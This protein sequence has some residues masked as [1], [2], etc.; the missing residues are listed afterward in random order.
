MFPDMPLKTRIPCAWRKSSPRSVG[1]LGH[2]SI[3]IVTSDHRPP[4][5][6]HHC[7]GEGSQIYQRYDSTSRGIRFLT[8]RVDRLKSSRFG[9]TDII[10]HI[11]QCFDESTKRLFN[12]SD[13][14]SY[15]QF[16]SP[17]EKAPSLGIQ[18]GKMKLS[19]SVSV[20]S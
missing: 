13:E 12:S 7:N 20:L 16:G 14:V 10:N 6:S 15:I 17:L 3:L 8:L 18:R 9:L 5:G 11:T 1:S 2:L 4:T 19:G